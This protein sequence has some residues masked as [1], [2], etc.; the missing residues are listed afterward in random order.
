M[1]DFLKIPYFTKK[2]PTSFLQKRIMYV[3]EALKKPVLYQPSSKLETL[4]GF[5]KVVL[6]D[7]SKEKAEIEKNQ[8]LDESFKKY[9]FKETDKN[10]A[11]GERVKKATILYEELMV[12]KAKAQK[13]QMKEKVLDF[14]TNL[15]RLGVFFLIDYQEIDIKVERNIKNS[16]IIFTIMAPGGK[17][18]G[19]LNQPQSELNYLSLNGAKF[20]F[21]KDLDYLFDL[22]VKFI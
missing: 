6:D 22:L 10:D 7:I 11:N 18:T 4:S 21:N 13:K 2:N 12:L 1:R 17:I 14:K 3:T 9:E 8:I 5:E 20:E 19:A 15:K 16:P